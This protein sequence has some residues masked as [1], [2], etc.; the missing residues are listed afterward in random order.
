MKFLFLLVI[1]LI[2]CFYPSES[3]PKFIRGRLFE[4]PRRLLHASNVPDQY[5]NQR[6]DH[7]DESQTATWNQRYWINDAF[8]DRKNGPV[9]IM[10]GGE[11][12]ENPIWIDG[13]MN[14]TW[15]QFAKKFVTQFLF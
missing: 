7:F 5:Y 8:F 2:T 6:L 9:F 14:T 12:E 4:K 11:G 10:I 15:I 13:K 1:V 3:L